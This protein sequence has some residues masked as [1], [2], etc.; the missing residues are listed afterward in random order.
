V[1]VPLATAL[2]A[3]DSASIDGTEYAFGFRLASPAGSLNTQGNTVT[4]GGDELILTGN[5]GT[6]TISAIRFVVGEFELE[7]EA[8]C[9]D[10][11][12]DG[13]DIGGGG[14]DDDGDDLDECEFELPPAFLTL[15]LD[16]AFT[17]I[18]D[19]VIPPGTYDE[20]EFEVENLDLDDDGD[21]DDDRA[22]LQRVISEV[23]AQYPLWPDGA[24][25]VI[26]GS[27]TPIDGSARSFQ[28]FARAEVEIEREFDP[29]LVV[30][31][32]G[33]REAIVIRVDP[34]AWFQTSEGDVLDLS[35]FDF[36]TTG[37]II[38]VDLDDGFLECEEDDEGH[39]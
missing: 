6:L 30:T 12:G 35:Q 33:R 25:A 23:R 34:A 39:D 21:D 32:D 11:D 8:S 31:A 3:C 20:F 22:E 9:E 2:A 17:P 7:S 24:G 18:G 16:G 14:G 28:V 27:F 38:E 1:V 29:P 19:V 36:A 5:N 4:A 26:E 15:P 10:H 13:H 37:E